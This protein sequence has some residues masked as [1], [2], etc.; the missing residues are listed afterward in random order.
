MTLLSR[1][2]RTMATV[3][4]VA[5]IALFT[6]ALQGVTSVD[7][8]LELAAAERTAPQ[9]ADDCPFRDRDRRHE[10]RRDREPAV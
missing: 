5:G 6:L 2:R 10:P 8:R 7:T 9:V 3:T 4:V 1:L